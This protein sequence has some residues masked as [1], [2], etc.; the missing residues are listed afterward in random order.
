MIKVTQFFLVAWT[1]LAVV[2]G[3]GV[4]LLFLQSVNPASADELV[5]GGTS[6]GSPEAAG[7]DVYVPNEFVHRS[8]TATAVSDQTIYYAPLDSNNHN[9]VLL[10][11]NTNA[12]TATIDLDFQTD[13]GSA[14]GSG[15]VFDI[16]SGA[17]ARVS[18]NSLDPG[19]PF[20]WGNTVIYNFFDTC[21][22]GLIHMPSKGV[23]VAGYVAWTATDVYNPR[24]LNPHA[25]IRF[26]SDPFSIF[27]PSVGS[28]P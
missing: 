20:S 21:E 18:A 23:H 15:V 27:L 16:P 7:A 2:T 28:A 5:P 9:T 3:I 25:E 10:F 12:I 4:S 26:S 13:I 8:D 19:R 14:C 24:E 17:S 1:C 6:E 22:I 11:Q